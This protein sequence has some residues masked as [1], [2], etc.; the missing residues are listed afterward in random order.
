MYIYFK[1]LFLI[2][3]IFN[4]NNLK[5]RREYHFNIVDINSDFLN[6]SGKIKTLAQLEGSHEHATLV[7]TTIEPLPSHLRQFTSG[8]REWRHVSLITIRSNSILGSSFLHANFFLLL[9]I[10]FPLFLSSCVTLRATKT[11]I[12]FLKLQLNS[13]GPDEIKM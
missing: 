8:Q 3:K 7:S 13:N 10:W 4:D 12:K 6:F 2:S 5:L 1:L 11:L 9:R